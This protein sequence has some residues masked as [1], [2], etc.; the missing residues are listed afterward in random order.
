MS[1]EQ[2]IKSKMVP[3]ITSENKAV[4]MLDHPRNRSNAFVMKIAE[5][6][7]EFCHSLLKPVAI[8]TSQ[9]NCCLGKMANILHLMSDTKSKDFFRINMDKG[10]SWFH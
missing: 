2:S 4:A 6:M 1:V 9:C 8:N 5:Q 3:A 7:F 10:W